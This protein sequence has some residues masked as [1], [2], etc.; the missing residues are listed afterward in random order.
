MGDEK[1]DEPS[2]PKCGSD[3]KEFVTRFICR[4]L[5]CRHE[6]KKDVPGFLSKARSDQGGNR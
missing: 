2:C 4:N 6:E 3:M 5:S 1:N